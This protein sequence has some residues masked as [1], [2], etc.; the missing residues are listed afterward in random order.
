MDYQLKCKYC[1]YLEFS[2]DL[3]A[4]TFRLEA[5]DF[6]DELEALQILLI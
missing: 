2:L 4:N 3:F 1:I 6:K 5:E